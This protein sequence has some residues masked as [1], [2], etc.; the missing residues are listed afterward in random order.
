MA[1]RCISNDLGVVLKGA[2]VCMAATGAMVFRLAM[3]TEVLS[4][5]TMCKSVHCGRGKDG[6][7]PTA[8]RPTSTQTR[9]WCYY[10]ATHQFRDFR[11]SINEWSVV[12]F[13]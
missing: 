8:L 6:Y 2:Q 11:V 3:R 1:R 12:C 7:R 10:V 4:R 13:L 5:Q 9:R